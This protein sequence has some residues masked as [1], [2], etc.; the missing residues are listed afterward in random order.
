MCDQL[1]CQIAQFL[2][3]NGNS[4]DCQVSVA[5]GNFLRIANFL[6]SSLRKLESVVME[7][8]NF[9][10]LGRPWQPKQIVCFFSIEVLIDRTQFCGLVAMSHCKT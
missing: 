10:P 8:S 6:V 9:L 7:T 5:S 3:P 2:E 4:R 1:K